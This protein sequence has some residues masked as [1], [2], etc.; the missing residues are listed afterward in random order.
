MASSALVESRELVVRRGPIKVLDKVTISINEGDVVSLVGANGAGKSTIIESLAGII[1]LREGRVIWKSDS[2]RRIIVRDSDGN[3][4]APPPFGL[5]L[6]KDGICGDETVIE[7][8]KSVISISGFDSI[9]EKAHELL[10]YWGLSHRSEDRVAHL[11]GGLRRRLSILCGLVPAA[12][13]NNPRV[14]LMDEPSEGLDETSKK[15]LI[16][17]IRALSLRNHAIIIATHDDDISVCANREIRIEDGSLTETSSLSSGSA[18][19]LPDPCPS[20]GQRTTESLISW[21]FKTEIRN[22]VETIG[23]ITP[24]IVA[25][26]L[27]YALI[28][29]NSLDSRLHASLI[30][31]PGFIAAASSPAL[32]SRLS[33]SDCG[34][35]WNAVVGPMSRPAL[36]VTASSIILP[37]PI[38]YLSW[39]VL[40]GSVDEQTYSAALTWLWLPSLVLIDIA[41]AATALHLLVAD[42]SRSGASPAPLL[43]LVLVWPFLQIV[44]VLAYIIDNGMSFGFELGDPI[45]ACLIASLISA[46][47][48]LAAVTIPDS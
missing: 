6:Q 14:V 32:I 34:R 33:E 25:L 38:T 47:V 19:N 22:P 10:D 8:V 27:S 7:R 40:S 26:L 9:E 30:F 42:L 48:W 18:C 15:T 17:W 21:S 41:I 29:G 28:S 13:S 3:R 37:I 16:A 12:L 23:R 31:A 39:Y 36:S 43:L 35:W 20:K 5:T 11:S 24:A 44:D 2:G 45:P 4:N 1:S 46:M